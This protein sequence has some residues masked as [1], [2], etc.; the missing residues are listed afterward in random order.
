[1]DYSRINLD[2]WS[3]KVHFEFFRSFD[4]P[5]HGVCV[6]V[7]VTPSVHFCKE[8][9]RSFFAHYLYALLRA[10]NQLR[11]MKLRIIDDLPVEYHNVD[12]SATLAKPDGTFGFSYVRYDEDFDTFYMFLQEEQK[13][14][15]QSEDLLPPVN[16][17]GCLHVSALPWL[18]FT[19]LSH[20]RDYG[21]GDSVPKVSFGKLH[22]V[23]GR[24]MMPMSV[25][26]HH[27]LVDGRDV[28]DLVSLF[29]E[30]MQSPS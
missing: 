9:Q 12:V 19:S 21:R 18:K 29:E 20:A 16:S 6:D 4:E 5:F 14:V 25:H 15:E 8:N 11:P 13:R 17:I 10:T 30:L 23:E 26:V 1:M 7:D 2:E 24:Q 22:D 27:S 28:A 3:R